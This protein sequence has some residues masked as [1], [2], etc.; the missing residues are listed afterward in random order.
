MEIHVALKNIL[1]SHGDNLVQ[2]VIL[3]NYLADEQCF[4]EFHAAKKI[5][6]EIIK[7]YGKKLYDLKLHNRPYKNEILK[8]KG[9]FC[10]ST[11][12]QQEMV[13]YL[14]DCISYGLLWDNTAMISL[15]KL[16]SSHLGDDNKKKTNNNLLFFANLYHFFGINVTCIKGKPG[17]KETYYINT[18]FSIETYHPFK[19]PSDHNWKSFFGEE[20]SIDYIQNQDWEEASGIGAVLGYK[21]LRALDFDCLSFLSPIHDYRVK[22]EI[23]VKKVLELLEL[24][25]DYQW[26]VRSGSGLGL[27]VIFRTKDISDFECDAVSFIPSK[28]TI[29]EGTGFERLELRWKDHLVLPPS[30]SI[31]YYNYNLLYFPECHG[32]RYYQNNFPN[33]APIEVEI[34]NLNNLLNFFCSE[35]DSVAFNKSARILGHRKLTTKI[36]SWG[37]D[38]IQFYATENWAKACLSN[39]NEE[40]ITFLLRN[41]DDKP[42]QINKA[43]ELLKQSNSAIS[44]YNLAS[45]IAKKVIQGTKEDAI[46][47]LEIAQRSKD[48]DPGDISLLHYYIEQM[49]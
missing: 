25:K 11:G 46:H 30:K 42:E 44:H 14:F 45:L 19:E 8:Y 41:S 32:Y 39:D 43:V 16:R 27:H 10:N 2:S 12:Y 24:P 37:G 38:H 4:E 31:G 6:K 15:N 40:Y 7:L 48:I 1:S 35:I 3:V 22:L 9:E 28:K 20:Q 5:L 34:D 26:V 21:G 29:E 18:G 13:E 17:D 47:H 36:D 23:F 49:K 33:Y